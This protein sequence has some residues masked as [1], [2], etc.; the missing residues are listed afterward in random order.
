[1][2]GLRDAGDFTNKDVYLAYLPL[3]HI[4]ELAAESVMLALGASIGYGSPQTLGDTGLK[5]APGTRGDAPTLRPTFVVFAPTVLDRVRQGVEAKVAAA[6]P[7]SQK[8]FA[9]ALKAG[10]KDFDN[11]KIGAPPL[12]NFLVFRKIQALLGGRIRVMVSGSA[13]LS[14]ETQKFIQTAFNCPVRQGYGLTETCSSATIGSFDDNSWSAGRV[15][16]SVKIM[17]KDWEEGG[18]KTADAANPEIRM[19]RGEVLIGGP[20]VAM[21]YYIDPSAPDAE[22]VAKNSSDFTTEADGCRYFHTGDIGQFTQNGMLQIID[23]KKD[24][25]KLQMGE[26]VALSKVENAMKLSPYVEQ[27]MAY[28][29]SSK[30]H[31]VALV[32]PNEKALRP[33]ADAKGFAGK[34]FELLCAEPAVVAEVLASVKAACAKGK[35]VG[36]EVPAA[37]GLVPEPWTPENDFVT[38]AIKLMRQTIVKAQQKL[39]DSIYK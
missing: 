36:F 4:M 11:G 29:L 34:D 12:W 35:L 18:Y 7:F 23:R 31:V 8:L 14:S 16:S 9:R 26:Y 5:I 2:T 32:V 22:L 30:S 24:L 21:G 37:V 19:P 15:I 28:A 25:V 38:A 1:M 10:A 27:C 6:S 20:C 33:W 39:L 17:L 13:P 3:A